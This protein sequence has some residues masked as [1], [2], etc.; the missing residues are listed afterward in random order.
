MR[1]CGAADENMYAHID[2]RR[3]SQSKPFHESTEFTLLPQRPRSSGNTRLSSKSEFLGLQVRGFC[4]PLQQRPSSSNSSSSSSSRT[5]NRVTPQS[6]GGGG[7]SLTLPNSP[8]GRLGS[9]GKP[10]SR[11]RTE[12]RPEMTPG[13]GGALCICPQRDPV[14]ETADTPTTPSIERRALHAQPGATKVSE[15]H[16][17]LP[18]SLMDD[19]EQDAQTAEMRT[20]AEDTNNE[21]P[22][23]PSHPSHTSQD[24]TNIRSQLHITSSGNI[25]QKDSEQS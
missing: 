3:N 17:Y 4:C 23:I 6:R 14:S 11:T 18:S 16:L 15:L 22:I 7:E 20:T 5:A 24:E 13:G 12:H 25:T 9:R 2:Q 19:E 1:E 8:T 21:N 10:A